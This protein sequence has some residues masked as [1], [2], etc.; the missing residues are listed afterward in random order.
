M[1]AAMRFS[2]LYLFKS[3]HF[4]YL[5]IQAQALLLTF[6]LVHNE[7]LHCTKKHPVY[8]RCLA[9]LVVI[10]LRLVK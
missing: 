7:H 10:W 1:D 2:A 9:R 3:F 5:S 8:T 6:R 4:E